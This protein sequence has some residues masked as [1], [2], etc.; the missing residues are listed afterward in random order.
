[1]TALYC[2]T[3]HKVHEFRRPHAAKVGPERATL[4][5]VGEIIGGTAIL[6]V[7]FAALAYGPWLLAGPR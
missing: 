1:M 2:P 5:D 7:L 3:C 6:L 4:R